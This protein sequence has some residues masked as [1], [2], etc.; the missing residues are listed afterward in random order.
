[1]NKITPRVSIA[2]KKL[3][4]VEENKNLLTSLINSIV[5]KEDKVA[6]ITLINPYNPKNFKDENLFLIDAKATSETGVRY[7]IETEIV[8]EG[9][10]SK[11]ALRYWSKHFAEKVYMGQKDFSFD[12][13]IGIHILNF[14]TIPQTLNYHNVF[15][16]LV[17]EILYVQDVEL[18]V[19]EL[20]KF[21]NNPEEN[22]A[23]ILKKIK[24]SLDIWITFFIRN[25]L[26]D[27][28][29]LPEELNLFALK[30]ALGVLEIMN[31]TN[32]EINLYENELKWLL[33]RASAI[34]YQKSKWYE[35]GKEKGIKIGLKKGHKIGRAEIRAAVKIA[36]A[37]EMHEKNESVEKIMK[38]THLTKEQIEDCLKTI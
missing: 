9:D 18:H 19:I 1:M 25:F 31:F 32:E 36:I 3:F 11:R 23:E 2:F 29:N 24:D 22:I 27:E 16:T 28:D 6:D 30:K 38:R 17:K 37:K 20:S 13:A 4:G 5:S 14:S 35:I 15:Y 10:Y 33:D 34:S 8:N 12:K 21:T 7:F 26:L